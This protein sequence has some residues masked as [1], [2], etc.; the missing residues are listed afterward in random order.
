MLRSLVVVALMCTAAVVTADKFHVLQRASRTLEVV[1][2]HSPLRDG[3]VVTGE[4]NESIMSTG[5]YVLSLVSNGNYSDADQAYAAGYFE[6]V[7]TSAVAQQSYLNHYGTDPVEDAVNQW[8]VQNLVW[9]RQ[10]VSQSQNQDPYWYQVGL[11]LQQ[12]EGLLDGINAQTTDGFQFNE[13]TLLALTAMGD[14]FDLQAAVPYFPQGIHATQLQRSSKRSSWNADWR[15]MSKRDFDRWF[16]KNTHCSSLFKVTDDM[17]D[18]FFGHAAWYDYSTMLRIFKHLTL[19]FNDP[20]TQSK[21]ISYSSYPGMLSSFD[22]FYLTDTGIAAIETSLGVLNLTMYQGNV[23]PQSV[24]YWMRVMVSTRTANN[25]PSWAS[26]M[27]KYNSGTYNNQWMILDLKKFTPGKPLP[28]DTMWLCEQLPGIV[29][30][31]DVTDILS[32]GYFPSYNIPLD[33]ELFNISGYQEAVATQGPQMNDY[34]TCVRA[35]IFRRDQAKVKDLASFQH[36]MRYNDFENDPISAGNPLYAIAARVDLDPL[37][38]GCFGALDAKVSSYSLWK[39]GSVIMSQSGPTQ[40]QPQ[41]SFNATLAPDCGRHVGL[42]ES[43]G[44]GWVAQKP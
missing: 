23:V 11:M 13:T 28:P 17:S 41:F 43:Y 12:F 6:G 29:K 27:A 24:M 20:M 5:W 22:D 10:Q 32:F 30:S 1:R 35:E 42:P 14:L 37:Q 7:V 3:V 25:A 31:R 9:V 18:I 39:Q 19:N 15:S 34:Q 4:F 21:T 40:Q 44:F 33:H 38:P 2:S 8:W 26:T 36:I 16:A